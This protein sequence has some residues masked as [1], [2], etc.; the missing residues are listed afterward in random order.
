MTRSI[1]LLPVLAFALA[2]GPAL[3]GPKCAGAGEKLAEAEVQKMYKGQGYEI[4]R[5]K[6]SSGG[7][8]EIYGKLNGKKVE[9]YI[10]PW[11]GNKVKEISG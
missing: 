11:T 7:C 4:N 5:W 1:L 8:Y 10:D 9:T 2:A 6:I 3:A